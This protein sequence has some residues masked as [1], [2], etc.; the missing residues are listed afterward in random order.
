M[1]TAGMV[2]RQRQSRTVVCQQ[3]VMDWF[4]AV[5]SRHTDALDKNR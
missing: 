4:D 5:P 3:P 2:R 1:V